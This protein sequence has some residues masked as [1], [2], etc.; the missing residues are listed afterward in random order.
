V[1]ANLSNVKKLTLINKVA[2]K[3]LIAELAVLEETA[4]YYNASP[5]LQTAYAKALED[6][7]AVYAN[8]HKQVQVDS[9]LANLVAAREQLNGQAT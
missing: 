2:L 5:E 6:A 1:L 8:K 3:E 7:N 4:R 9:A